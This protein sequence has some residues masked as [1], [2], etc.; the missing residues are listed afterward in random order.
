[1][2]M[3]VGTP[4]WTKLWVQALDRITMTDSSS[5]RGT[6]RDVPRQTGWGALLLGFLIF[7]LLWILYIPWR[8]IYMPPDGD[9]IAILADGSL[10]APGARWQDW[11]T[12]GYSHLY[13][14]YP[15]WQGLV[16]LPYTTA[17]TR[18][19]FQFVIY[20]AHIVLGQDWASYQLINNFAAAGMG[21]VA[22]YIAQTV[23]ELRTGPS[24]VAAILVL[25]SPPVLN[26]WWLGVG[27]AVE[28][29][30][31][32]LVTGAFLAV[33]ARSD[34]VCLGFLFA[35][36]LTKENALW[37]PFAAAATILLRPKPHESRR[38]QVLAAATM[39]LPV[40][41][42]LGLRFAFFGGFGG[43][44][45]TMGYTPLADFVKLTFDKL[46][47][48][49]YPLIV[50]N[51]GPEIL[52]NRGTAL[53]IL[54]RAQ[55][56]LIY[57]LLSL[58]ALR[59]VSETNHLRHAMREKRW[60]TVDPI[61]LVTL[62]A[63]FALAFDF[64]LPMRND[65]YATSIVVF[66]WPALVAEVERRGKTIIWFG[67]AA[68]FVL[69]LTRS[70]YLYVERIARPVRGGDYRSMSAVLHQAPAGTRQIYILAAGS[71]QPANPEYVRLALGVPAEVVRVAEIS[72]NC[73]DK[74][75]LV[76][77]DHTS[78]DG[79]V[80]MTIALP[81]CANFYFGN[82]V[83]IANGRLR[84]NDAITYELPEAHPIN[85]SKW[86]YLGRRMTVHVRPNGPA[87]FII[88]HGGADGIAWF[89]TP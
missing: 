25:L 48:L 63:A 81:A 5:H 34:F 11:F 23:L 45:A 28:P 8:E 80:S 33:L 27:F 82:P 50:H 67:L 52:R 44:Y 6:Q 38:N 84:R 49:H 57:A 54:D 86:W 51:V 22:F 17:F 58:W 21:A 87:R 75:D 37:A 1:M 10:L 56:V 70:S 79:I 14:L 12:R 26:S 36:L 64:A 89:D 65:R 73:R 29:L 60:P 13:D 53:L 76:R 74:G 20:L 72:W 41:I 30:T 2:T 18:P 39:L 71:L 9:S 78:A 35:A 46:T 77:F 32:V 47:H 43:T 66:A 68:C 7:G 55:A 85:A 69:S 16:P 24:L 4:Y 88:E 61:L 40:A 83:E 59:T 19:A 3:R 31:T 15:D 62:W 42:W